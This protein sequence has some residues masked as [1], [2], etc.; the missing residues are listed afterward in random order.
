MVVIVRGS[1]MCVGL[2][3]G[4]LCGVCSCVIGLRCCVHVNVCSVLAV[5]VF[6]LCNCFAFVYDVLPAS[7]FFRL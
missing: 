1:I 2:F 6:V 7:V 3:G 4:L 5:R